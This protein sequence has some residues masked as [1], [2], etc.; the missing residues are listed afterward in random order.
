M[1]AEER[2][3]QDQ[4]NFPQDSYKP[5]LI[6]CEVTRRCNLACLHC[7]ASAQ[8]EP[9]PDELTGEEWMRLIDEIA[10][11]GKP[12]LILTGGEPTLRR[13]IYE[14]AE[15][16][17]SKGLRVV[18]SS[19]GININKESTKRMKNA[20]IKRLS[21]SLDGATSRTHDSFRGVKG[22]FEKAVRGAKEAK[23]ADLDLQ[24]NTTITRLNLEEV[25]GI[26]NLAARLG[27]VAYHPF[28]LVPVGRASQLKAQ[29]IPAEEYEKLL[30]W[31]AQIREKIALPIKV[32]CAPHYYRILHQRARQRGKTVSAHTQ[33]LNAFTQGCLGGTAFCFISFRGDVQP[34]G[35]L[36]LKCGNIREKSFSE[37]W[38]NSEVLNDLRNIGKY[39]GKCGRCEFKRICG[40]CRARAY[41]VSGD[42]LAEEPYCVYEPATRKN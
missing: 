34:C 32:T 9:Y 12:I 6:A 30:C 13:D 8:S 35:Y 15:H 4:H 17:S 3:R 31:F 16:A 41:S 28:L 18:L 1:Q 36:E 26:L 19:N 10:S 38:R 37:I 2:N 24:I 39:Q 22:A 20:G 33:G 21:I 14:I 7:R 42:C 29:E 40:G 25:P 5:R 23:E 11:L 27:V